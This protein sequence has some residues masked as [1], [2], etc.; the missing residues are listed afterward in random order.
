MAL[1]R[2]RRGTRAEWLG[3]SRVLADGEPGV[4]IDTGEVRF[5]NG[6]A[7]WANLPTAAASSSGSQIVV[8]DSY[9]QAPAGLPTG[10]V[11]ISR[12]GS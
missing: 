3:S 9:A 6:T 1:I 4:A 8:V 12:T 5:G 7:T 10:T 2:L 11:V